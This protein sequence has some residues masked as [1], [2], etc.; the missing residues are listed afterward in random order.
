MIIDSAPVG[1]ADRVHAVGAADAVTRISESDPL[2]VVRI[3]KHERASCGGKQEL[4]VRCAQQRSDLRARR[5]FNK[6]ARESISGRGRPAKSGRKRG[7][8]GGYRRA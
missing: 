1:G 5:L 3:W 2:G 4:K 8:C 6:T 7:V